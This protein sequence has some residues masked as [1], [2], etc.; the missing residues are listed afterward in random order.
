MGKSSLA[1]SWLHGDLRG[2]DVSIGSAIPTDERPKGILWYSFYESKASISAFFHTALHYF[3]GV[4]KEP[5]DVISSLVTAMQQQR[6]LVV[7]D[8]LERQLLGFSGLDQPH[9]R[10][11][12]DSIRYFSDPRLRE[13]LRTIASVPGGGTKILITSRLMP[14]ELE[15]LNGVDE[16]Q[17]PGLS[18][19]EAT[20][21]LE[22][23]TQGLNKTFIAD[24]A[25][26]YCSHPLAL[27]L[28]AGLLADP[29]YDNAAL[30]AGSE[31]KIV[32]ELVQREH[33]V[34]EQAYEA[35]SGPEQTFLG[36]IS[37][38]RGAT[39]F[40]AAK[41]VLGTKSLDYFWAQVDRL[42]DR[43]LLWVNKHQQEFDLHPIVRLYC[44]SR[45]IDKTAVADR[46]S[47]VFESI[48]RP[49]TIRT[50]EQAE[51]L[52]EITYQYARAGRYDDACRLFDDAIWMDL[53]VKLDENRLI[54]D[55]IALFF[56]EGWAGECAVLDQDL[57]EGLVQ[58][59]AQ[60]LAST[61][62]Y[63][64]V[65]ALLGKGSP[66][67]REGNAQ[68]GQFFG[69]ALFET[70]LCAAGIDE[71]YRAL[72]L[73][74]DEHRKGHM[75]DAI[76]L[77]FSTIHCTTQARYHARE[78]KGCYKRSRRLDA[79]HRF[80]VIFRKINVLSS[81]RKAERLVQTLEDAAKEL[82]WDATTK[83]LVQTKAELLIRRLEAA[84]GK[85]SRVKQFMTGVDGVA[86]VD[87]ADRLISE[88]LGEAR[89][90]G[91][92]PLE[93]LL[94]RLSARLTVYSDLERAA[95]AA[96]ESL[97]IA[98]RLDSVF[99]KISALRVLSDVEVKI[100]EFRHGLAHLREA[101]A[102]V[103]K[104]AICEPLRSE[105]ATELHNLERAAPL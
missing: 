47:G 98:R 67:R 84:K 91:D 38:F 20:E 2:T 30:L 32:D 43:G 29:G 105:I 4:G 99:T 66:S 6:G 28:A 75:H 62:R 76:A 71:M 16:L 1:W 15:G 14:I 88:L 52:L 51:P 24:V 21:F 42:V 72:N 5:T 92:T 73:T 90:T 58:K 94:L 65:V 102:L 53:G 19:D 26:T 33:H 46:I 34:L 13:L 31:P 70:G 97:R 54:L 17:I 89:N 85:H 63:S 82:G 12:E 55:L 96:N 23:E 25:R 10:E 40:D 68:V 78:M 35:L 100:G 22:R 27:R 57:G 3:L 104:D 36:I 87:E 9:R 77:V 49:Q 81:S 39:S 64:D 8:G 79:R 103:P 60:V 86:D 37:A 11:E 80:E 48:P 50:R 83:L 59:T 101:R 44:Y 61:G 93:G 18:E 74:E 56:P 45:L 95:A 41:A 7:L 69:R